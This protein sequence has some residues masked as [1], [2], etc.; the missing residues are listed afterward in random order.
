M[1]RKYEGARQGGTIVTSSCGQGDTCPSHPTPG[2]RALTSSCGRGSHTTPGGTTVTSSSVFAK[3]AFALLLF[4]PL[5]PAQTVELPPYGE[6][7]LIDEIDCSS[8]GLTHRFTDSPAGGS[9][10]TN[11]LGSACRAMSTL[12]NEATYISYR[13]GEGK[14]LQANGHYVV[15]V[16]YPED[17]PRTMIVVNSGNETSQGFHTG[18][19]VGDALYAN[20]TGHHCESLDLPLAGQWECWTMYMRLHNRTPVNG[21]VRGNARPRPL[22][23][24]D[25]FTVAMAQFTST[26]A[27][28]SSGI[29]VRRIQLYEVADPDILPVALR[30]PPRSLP[31]RRVF[32]REEMADDVIGND[33]TAPDDLGVA[34]ALDWYRHKAR[35]ARFLGFNT[36]T[37]DLLEFGACQH[38]DPRPYG[39]NNWVHYD[40]VLFGLWSQI[41]DVMGA[42]GLDILPYY[43]YSGS[44]GNNGLGFQRR[45][46]PLTRDDY[47]T[48][49]KWIESA[50]ADITDPDTYAD[51]KKMLDLTIINMQDKARFV[52]AWLRPRSQLPVGFGDATRARFAAEANGGV[53]VTRNQLKS[54]TTLYNSYLAWWHLKRRDFLSA[55]RDYLRDE[56]I[57]EAQVL[58]TGCAAEPGVG[59]PDWTSRFVTERPDLWQPIFTAIG[60]PGRVL[61][62]PQQVV[63]QNLY[64]NGLVSPGLNWAPWE[65]HHANPADDPSNYQSLE[66][67][68]LTHAFN[69]RYTVLDP[70]SMDMYRTR[71]GLAMV[72]HYGLNEDMLYD[73]FNKPKLGYSVVDIERAG[74]ACM[75]AEVL[76]VANGDPTMIGYLVGSNFVRG[77]PAV[78]R[79]FNANFLA[80]PALPS[81]SLDS[82]TDNPAIVVRQIVTDEHGT[83]LMVI[84]PTTVAHS[85]VAVQVPGG[86]TSLEALVSGDTI[87]TPGGV[88]TLD[89]L[90]HQLVS[91]GIGTANDVEI[92]PE[93][94]PEPE[95]LR[96]ATWVPTVGGNLYDWVA[97]E[98]WTGD[99]G[100]PRAAGDIANINNSIAGNQTIRLRSDITLGRLN[101]GDASENNHT[102]T[103]GNAAGE[104]FTL[105]FDSG[106]P[107]VPA[108]LQLGSSGKS[109]NTLNVPIELQSDLTIDFAGIDAD[110]YNSVTLNSPVALGNHTIEFVNGIYGQQHVSISSG[111]SFTGDDG[112]I[113]NNSSSVVWVSGNQNFGGTLIANGRAT[114]S[115]KGTFTFTYGG[116][117]NAAELVINGY[118]TGSDSVQG[119]SIQI[120]QNSPTGNNPG[121]LLP[122]HRITFNGGQMVR[123]SLYTNPGDANDWQK[124]LEWAEDE[125]DYWNFNS[126]YNY[127]KITAPANTPGTRLRIKTLARS[128]GASVYFFGANDPRQNFMAEN[129]EVFLKGA[130]GA[131][132]TTTRSI[133]PWIGVHTIGGY[134]NPDG[135]ATYDA[136]T[137]IRA[138]DSATEYA[139][140]LS[141]GAD[142]NVSV[143]NPA[144][145]SDATV[146]S[147]RYTGYGG[148]I[149]AGRTLTITSGGIF[150]TGNGTI[151]QKGNDNAGTLDFGQAEACVSVHANNTAII[152]AAIRGSGGFS[153]IQTGTLTLTGDN[154][155]LSGP[156]H[157][158]GGRLRVGDGAI[159]GSLGS[160]DVHIHN[161]AVLQV[162][163]AAAFSETA[164]LH[165]LS[166]GPYHGKVEI[167]AGFNVS[168]ARL[169]VAG[170]GQAAGTYGGAA[171]DAQYKLPQYFEGSGILTVTE[172]S[173][174]GVDPGQTSYSDWAATIAWQG[175][176]SAPDAD[177]D[178]DGLT[179]YGEFIAG[180]DPLDPASVLRFTGIA[181]ETGGYELRWAS[182]AGREYVLEAAEALAGPWIPVQTG[183][184]ATPPENSLLLP[185]DP[186]AVPS[187][188]Y[189]IV[190]TD[191]K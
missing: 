18:L 189:R 65:V 82:A 24:A 51:F 49:I 66:G 57:E 151:G 42:A 133:I 137:G 38:W 149:G 23:P 1:I 97:S 154:N 33:E 39:G 87:A 77:W 158:G 153:K 60:D 115:N 99:F 95:L 104:N 83:Y 76:A 62:T 148:N 84:N 191:E 169:Y 32:W 19:A 152:G 140:S 21:M 44:K 183:I 181:P 13:L 134:A 190:I 156:V 67:V 81:Q 124:G 161:G 168:A 27:P 188:F 138:L 145:S 4:A 58:F 50:N 93:D 109:S 117:T 101:L 136:G 25:G 92:A 14:G 120:G 119:A 106:E 55:M 29:A 155:D 52:G 150:F 147:L 96:E 121:Q 36:Y 34:P 59:F 85:G 16:E 86:V 175:A 5:A 26:N 100:H 110:N 9:Y 186:D 68:M 144:L 170:R 37:K 94:I 111:S 35:T 173:H 178:G 167:D 132:N 127:V 139:A 46:L 107:A 129:I 162:S 118:L 157:V 131:A 6:V 126:G 56:G 177:P 146:N 45:C 64:Q 90:P 48:H 89:L 174:D 7:T 172:D 171:S 78:V 88:L 164:S 72:R 30:M 53:S 91:F 114:G 105:T 179:N 69:R 73:A 160:G 130:S 2:K 54:N 142:H 122:R 102:F 187:T 180:T 8:D 125:V 80:L 98:N 31:R 108:L 17:A 176:D 63:Q 41:V 128:A 79:E 103:L 143:N 43:E 184:A 182:E 10:V 47:Y 22:L 166:Y 12:T 135:F 112:R 123:W 163:S 74:R 141:A 159:S 71:N 165:L 40:S 11:I 28:F 20:Y 3:I 15:T 70:A 113:V 116:F 185:V 75:E 61:L